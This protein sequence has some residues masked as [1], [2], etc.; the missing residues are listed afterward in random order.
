[1]AEV[2]QGPHVFYIMLAEFDIDRGSTLSHQYPLPYNGK[3]NLAE[4]MLPDGAHKREEDWT[5]F[6]L[7]Q[8]SAEAA[9]KRRKTAS[10]KKDAPTEKKETFSERPLTAFIYKYTEE[11]QDWLMITEDQKE[12]S[13]V[14]RKDDIAVSDGNETL[15]LIQR[16]DELQHKR[17][18]PLY[19]CVIA[20]D[21]AYGFRFS[22]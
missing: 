21:A 2:Q 9:E 7:N 3:E 15:F 11:S 18:E 13:V 6:F 17:I 20:N 16:S 5:V 12:L 10:E 1:M 14:L 8:E 22:E 19:H 4:L